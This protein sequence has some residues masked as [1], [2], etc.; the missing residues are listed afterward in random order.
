MT[1]DTRKRQI[2]DD[3]IMSVNCAVSVSFR[4]YGQFGATR[5]RNSGLMVCNPYIFID[6][7]LFLTKTENIAKIS[8]SQLSYYCFQ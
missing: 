5:K 3:E 1:R 2:G 8:L 7:N 4:I 6:S